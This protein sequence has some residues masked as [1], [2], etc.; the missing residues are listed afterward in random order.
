MKS[1]F[2]R[3]SLKHILAQQEAE[4]IGHT[5]HRNLT[6]TDLTAFGVAAI[7]GAGI[8]STIGK[9]ASA[10]GPAVSLLFVFTAIACGLSAM[11]YAAFASRI[12]ISGSAY[13]YAYH[14]FGEI[15]AWIIG[16][17]LI[18]EYAVGNVAVAI[19]WSG[20]FTG[21]LDAL[22][23]GGI[24]FH[25]PEWMSIDYFSAKEQFEGAIA[26]LNN[27]GCTCSIPAKFSEGYQAWLHAPDPLGFKMIMDLPAFAIVVII[28]WLVFR[29]IKESKR[30]SNMMVLLKLAV[31]LFVIGLGSSFVDFENWT[32]FAPEGIS[33][34]LQGISGVFFAYIGFDAISTTAEECK[35][36][37]RD[38]P[39]SMFYALLICTVLYVALSL[40]LTGM[41]SYKNLDVDDP[42]A[43]VFGLVGLPQVQFVVGA[44]AIIAM[45]SVLLVFQMGQPRIWM[46]MSRDGLL[47][48][49][50]S[51]IHPRFQT[52]WFSTLV[53]GI[54]VGVPALF[55]TLG[56]MADL[57]SI[58]TLFA[59]AL[60]CGGVLTLE[61][62][63]EDA[64]HQHFRI[65]YYNGKYIIPT[66]FAVGMTLMA[67]FGTETLG[68]WISWSSWP[69]FQSVLPG[70]IFF[71]FSAFISWLSFKK[72]WSVIP[73]L[74]LLS[75]VYLMTE[76]NEITW[77]GFAVWLVIG[78]I[79]YFGYGYRK[80]RLR[81]SSVK[82]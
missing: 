45:A 20:Y 43:Y 14:A 30:A 79:I 48:R 33:G 3:K 4:Q 81:N 5:L 66:L 31:I 62:P 7:I 53:A 2:R 42:L 78:L 21:W 70:I 24:S 18:M 10:G 76:L 17:D 26:Y 56:Q 27:G 72:Q 71:L 38:L 63:E 55:V 64:G 9:A 19:S 11:C 82:S 47:P 73:V 65:P 59:F 12:P 67:I 77:K 37:R 23:I 8:F 35:N 60:V 29:G 13:T 1:L 16:W 36:P 68:K 40:V 44:S 25:V 49:R 46:S 6:V 34:V 39:R 51:S 74:G 54:L 80:S 52:P 50:F 41:T 15:V 69:E 28:S 61:E 75:N 22:K 57:T 58:G 32:P